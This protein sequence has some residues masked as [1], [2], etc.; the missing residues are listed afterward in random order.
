[1]TL[2]FSAG[3]L[4]PDSLVVVRCVCGTRVVGAD[5]EKRSLSFSVFAQLA[6]FVHLGHAAFRLLLL[7]LVPALGFFALFLLAG[8]FLLT[9]V[10]R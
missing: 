7:A 4:L 2:F 9:L 10:K 8:L 6:H 3:S 5:V 1:M